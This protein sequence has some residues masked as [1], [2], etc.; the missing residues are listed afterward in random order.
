LGARGRDAGGGD[1]GDGGGDGGDGADN[2]ADLSETL[3]EDDSTDAGS[4]LLPEAW[5]D[6]K[7]DDD[8]LS[9]LGDGSPFAEGAFIVMNAHYDHIGAVARANASQLI[10]RIMDEIGRTLPV[11]LL[12]DFNAEPGTEPITT[13]LEELSDAYDAPGVR[14]SGPAGT[15]NGFEDREAYDARIDYVFH[16]R[17]LVPL[18]HLV[19]DRR[20]EGLFPSDHFPV[21][22][23]LRW[24]R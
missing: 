19:F 8:D 21:I 1:G 9:I 7:A 18:T 16:S 22:V 24:N 4:D 5:F 10:L 6:L 23:D 3:A 11:I 20:I 12:G 17:D 14:R 15:F 2:L 13:L